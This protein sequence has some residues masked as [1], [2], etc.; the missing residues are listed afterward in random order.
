MKKKEALTHHTH[1]TFTISWG[2]GRE[3][4]VILYFYSGEWLRNIFFLLSLNARMDESDC[5]QLLPTETEWLEPGIKRI[6]TKRRRN[7]IR[8]KK[9][10]VLLAFGFFLSVCVCV[11]MF[12]DQ[13]CG[14]AC[15]Y[16]SGLLLYDAVPLQCPLT[17]ISIQLPPSSSSSSSR[18]GL[19]ESQ[20]PTRV[21]ISFTRQPIGL[22]HF[23]HHN[24]RQIASSL[25]GPKREK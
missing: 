6:L 17:N 20:K 18:A 10:V 22:L 8:R 15:R 23:N 14:N 11:C 21:S 24:S 2:E 5:P 16:C 25:N 19:C 13:P 1:F 12:N 4:I 3:S 9:F 7:R